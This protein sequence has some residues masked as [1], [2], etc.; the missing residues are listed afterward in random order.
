MLRPI[1][2]FIIAAKIRK[3]AAILTGSVTTCYS[4]SRKVHIFRTH[5]VHFKNIDFRHTPQHSLNICF[6]TGKL[7][8]WLRYY[9]LL[10]KLYCLNI[11][12]L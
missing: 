1:Y 6:S 11:S 7:Q 10:N 3:S 4:N 9:C 5:I 2:A 8:P 12:P